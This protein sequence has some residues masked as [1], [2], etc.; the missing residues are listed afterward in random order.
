MTV[1][2]I[3]RCTVI[4]FYY[5]TLRKCRTTSHFRHRS[6]QFFSPFLHV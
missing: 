6:I 5:H 3:E 2:F 1:Q 4:I